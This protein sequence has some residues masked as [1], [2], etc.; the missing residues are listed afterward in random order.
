MNIE[1]TEFHIKN[2]SSA[3]V[4]FIAQSFYNEG[5]KDLDGGYYSLAIGEFNKAKELFA[6]IDHD[7]FVTRCEHFIEQAEEK[8]S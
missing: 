1:A 8:Q 4:Q 3:E 5:I 7:W 2:L 6:I